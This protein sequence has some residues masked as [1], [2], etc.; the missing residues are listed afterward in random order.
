MPRLYRYMRRML[1]NKRSTYRAP[2]FFHCFLSCRLS[3]NS[4][5]TS[6]TDEHALSRNVGTRPLEV[7]FLFPVRGR[8][9]VTAEKLTR[10]AT[11]I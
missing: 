9:V 4:A 8:V 5:Q 11:L 6:G 1:K 7:G 3:R 10:P 2:L